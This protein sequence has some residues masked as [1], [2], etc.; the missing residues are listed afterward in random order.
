MSEIVKRIKSGDVGAFEET[1]HRWHAKLYGYILK[2][3]ASAALAEEVVQHAFV[4]V[5]IKRVDLSEEYPIE[6]QLFR[7]GRTILIDELRKAAHAKAYGDAQKH[8]AEA[9]VFNQF[10]YTDT[11]DRLEDAISAM[12]PI[13]QKVFRMSR[14][15][16]K[17]YQEIAKQ[18]SISPKT[19]EN[20]I[21][22]A[23]KYLRQ[24]SIF[25]FLMSL[26]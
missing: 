4:R 20:H 16:H 23:L 3:T 13:R 19:V 12:P 21:A 18:L 1:F 15:E 8:V 10:D 24:L 2:K 22:L 26:R 9:I 5:W 14:F 17:S 6:V 7:I 11:M 25:L